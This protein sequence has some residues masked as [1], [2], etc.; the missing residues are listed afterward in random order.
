MKFLKLMQSSLFALALLTFAGFTQKANAQYVLKQVSVSVT[1]QEFQGLYTFGVIPVIQ[2]SPLFYKGNG[3]GNGT[4][5]WPPIVHEPPCPDAVG[6]TPELAQQMTALAN[7][8]CH[9]VYTC[10]QEEDCG[11]YMYVFKPTSPRCTF[12]AAYQSVLKAYAL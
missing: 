7:Q 4:V 8:Y 1:L 10:V 3:T 6:M 12:T 2:S 5:P 11:W 9:D